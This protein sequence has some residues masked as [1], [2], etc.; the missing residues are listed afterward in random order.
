MKKRQCRRDCEVPQSARRTQSA[1]V[2]TTFPAHQQ[3]PVACGFFLA[4][5][6]GYPACRYSAF[7]VPFSPWRSCRIGRDRLLPAHSA[8]V[9]AGRRAPDRCRT[10][11]ARSG[12]S[13]LGIIQPDQSDPS[14]HSERVSR[15][16]RKALAVAPVNGHVAKS[17]AVLAGRID[18]LQRTRICFAV[19]ASSGMCARRQRS[20]SSPSRAD[21][22]GCRVRSLVVPAQGRED[23]H[24]AITHRP[25]HIRATPADGSLF[26]KGT[27]IENQRCG[28]SPS[29]ASA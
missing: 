3:M 24:L 7:S 1:G 16:R 18:Q 2:R 26:C 23:V 25:F 9:S 6:C 15:P 29:S 28:S 8:T 22:G 11:T 21:T 5:P 10:P 12:R 27:F 17:D 4:I 19:G 14:A 13:M 20:A